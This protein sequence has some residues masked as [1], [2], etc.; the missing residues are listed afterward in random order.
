MLD[1]HRHR[2]QAKG[3]VEGLALLEGLSQ[4][5]NVAGTRTLVFLVMGI[6]RYRWREHAQP[7]RLL[8]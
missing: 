3:H 8:W 2:Q 1:K 4:N 6:Q 5:G 7:T